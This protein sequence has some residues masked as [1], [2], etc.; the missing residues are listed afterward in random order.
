MNFVANENSDASVSSNTPQTTSPNSTTLFRSAQQNAASSSPLRRSLFGARGSYIPSQPQ[1]DFT[2]RDGIRPSATST[3]SP[4]TGNMAP[5]PSIANTSQSNARPNRPSPAPDQYPPTHHMQASDGLAS[6]PQRPPYT[7]PNHAVF[8]YWMRDLSV[9]SV[10]P[11]MPDGRNMFTRNAVDQTDHGWG[12]GV[13]VHADV[14]ADMAVDGTH[15][16]RL[17]SRDLGPSRT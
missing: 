15:T 13:A 1:T 4:S 11:R 16:D 12:P 2:V 10:L 5:P 8:L 7:A 6:Q 17:V 3:R 9:G 14:R